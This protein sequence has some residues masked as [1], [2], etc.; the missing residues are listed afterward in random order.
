[1][2]D[3]RKDDLAY[4]EGNIKVHPKHAVYGQS[5]VKRPAPVNKAMKF[6]G[7]RKGGAF[8]TTGL[9]TLYVVRTT[10]VKLRLHVGIMT[11]NTENE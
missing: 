2:G 1:V 3:N 10:L 7:P 5:V 9:S 11:F 8:F 4:Y 6:L